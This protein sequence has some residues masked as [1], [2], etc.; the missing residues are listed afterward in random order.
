MNT[1]K[2]SVAT[3][4][5]NASKYLQ[6][7]IDSVFNQDYPNIEFIIIDG[8]STD[9]TLE[10]IKANSEK[11][12]FTISEPDKGIYDAMNKALYY[13]TGDFIIFMGAGD[14]FYNNN[15]ISSMVCNFKEKDNIYY[16]NVILEGLN[17]KYWGRFTRLKWAIGNISHQAIFY[18]QQIYKQYKY[19]LKYKVYADYAYN[20]QL[21]QSYP[22]IYLNKIITLYDMNG[23]S[24]Y[25]TDI[26]FEKD[27]KHLIT[28]AC[29]LHNYIIGYIIRHLMKWK[30]NI[31]IIFSHI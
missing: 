24:T 9:E 5:Y 7:T 1:Y 21:L 27:R 28:K 31:M 22:F 14:I 13:A 15:V 25:S 17:K 29:G 3:V 30:K 23:F 12:S 10:I 4:T 8:Q 26:I 16:G 6:K 11:I 19:N 2:I 20:L 18:P